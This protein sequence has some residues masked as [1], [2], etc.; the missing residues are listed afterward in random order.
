MTEAALQKAVIDTARLLGWKVAHFHDS[1]RQVRPGVFVGDRD[2]AGFPDLVLVRG[3]RLL[4]VELKAEKGRLSP[5]QDAWIAALQD[6]RRCGVAVFR[7]SDW[8]N[9]TVAAVLQEKVDA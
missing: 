3:G 8:T 1:R 5:E 9:G 6:S 4:F 7:P 2:A